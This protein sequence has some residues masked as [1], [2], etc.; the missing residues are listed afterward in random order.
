MWQPVHRQNCVQS[1]SILE[2]W[3]YTAS[4]IS[5]LTFSA[6][7]RSLAVPSCSTHLAKFAFV[8]GG[9]P[10]RT[11]F[12]MHWLELIISKQASSP[13]GHLSTTAWAL[14][15][16]VRANNRPTWSFLFCILTSFQRRLHEV[17]KSHNIN[18]D[19]LATI[20][21]SPSQVTRNSIYI[22]LS[23]YPPPGYPFPYMPDIGTSQCS[24]GLD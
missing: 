2:P 5:S 24:T 9:R 20:L 17:L 7:G 19:G 22:H 6:P 8:N 12:A 10:S 15:T 1:M 23:S 14:M 16:A 13:Q 11:T 21:R 4:R 18:G 3:P